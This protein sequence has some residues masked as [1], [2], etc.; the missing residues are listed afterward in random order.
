MPLGQ[1]FNDIKTGLGSAM[2]GLL[3]LA[4]IVIMSLL[5][6]V[7]YKCSRKETEEEMQ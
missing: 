2:I 3:V 7:I 5:I 6:C 1:I 4:C